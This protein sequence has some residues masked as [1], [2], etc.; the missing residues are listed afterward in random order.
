AGLTRERFVNDPATGEQLFPLRAAV[1]ERLAK[2]PGNPGLLELRAELAGQ[3]S[4]AKAQVADYT[5]AI[6][7][8]SKQTPKA[9]AV[10]LERLYGRRG[11]AY[12]A[13]RQWQQALD[14]YARIITDATTDD[15]LLSNQALAQAEVLLDRFTMRTWTPL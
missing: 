3:W 14:D 13:S 11:N 4:D 12:V 8:L 1:N 5:A 9:R 7:T 2:E 10:D 6:E 15:A